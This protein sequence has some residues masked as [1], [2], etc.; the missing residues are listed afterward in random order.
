MS[1][2]AKTIQ[3]RLPFTSNSTGVFTLSFQLVALDPPEPIKSSRE[4]PN[5]KTVKAIEDAL[6]GKNVVRYKSADDMF[7]K[8]GI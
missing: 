3:G 8:L 5:K 4:V 7:R 6:A 1:Q 2:V